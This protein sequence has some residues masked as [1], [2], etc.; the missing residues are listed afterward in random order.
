MRK[1]AIGAGLALLGGAAWAAWAVA[2]AQPTALSVRDSDF[3]GAHAEAERAQVRAAALDRQARAATMASERATLAAAALAAR[4]QQAEAALAAANEDQAAVRRRLAALDRKLARERAPVAQLLAGLQSQLRQPPL[5]ALLQ[6]GSLT[7]T[8]R[9]RAVLDTVGRQ[10][11]ARTAELRAAAARARALEREAARISVQRRAMR[12]ALDERRA[13][14]AAMAAAEQLKARRAAG[15]A[16]SEAERALAL[17][18]EAPDLPGLVRRIELASARP[19]RAA[20][21]A[22]EAGSPLLR[23]PVSGALLQPEPGNDFDLAILPRPGAQ[24]VAPGPGRVGFAGPFRGYGE[25]VIIEHGG[26]WT[27]LVTGLSSAQVSVG[28]QL[29]GGSPLGRAQR[30]SPRIG[31]E[32]RRNGQRVNPLDQLR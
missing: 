29:V 3:A 16:S 5:L 7:E 9:L 21:G 19:S 4:V 11:T 14:L 2:P 1:R 10:V 28:Q 27:S 8:V 15:A 6:P 17:A 12:A 13:E 18:R 32:L 24:V 30:L 22:V 26:G 25:I 20:S 23:L 31:L